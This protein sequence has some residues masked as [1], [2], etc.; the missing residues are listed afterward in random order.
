MEKNA[1]FKSQTTNKAKHINV[2][3]KPYAKQNEMDI[4]NREKKNRHEWTSQ[5]LRTTKKT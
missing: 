4:A 5:T 1:K 2:H 3:R